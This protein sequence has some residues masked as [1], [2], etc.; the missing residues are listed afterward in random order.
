[1]KTCMFFALSLILGS[2]VQGQPAGKK[3]LEPDLRKLTSEQL[4]A[5]FNDKNVCGTADHFEI[6]DELVR[7]LPTLPTETLVACFDNWRICGTG[8]N[9]ASGWPIS[10]ELA[11]RGNPHALLVRYWTE[12]KESIRWGIVDVAYHFKTPEVTAFMRKVFEGGKGDEGFL[13]WP[14]NYLAKQCDAEALKWFGTRSQRSQSCVQYAPTISLF[15]KCKYRPA[16]PYL[17]EYSLHDACLN[18]DDAA[19]DD[20]H[21]LY[22]GSP[23]EFSNLQD[24][25]KYYCRR[26]IQEGFHPKCDL[27]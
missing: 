21:K 3:T 12:P 2:I 25:Q 10:D 11:H 24:L 6:S 4:K 15:G 23:R 14:A 20:L 8:E 27:Q 19:A 1:M 22:P 26:A 7:R 13:Y 5:C 18:I 16:I 17:L 9:Q